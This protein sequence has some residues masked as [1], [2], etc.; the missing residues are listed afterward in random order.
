MIFSDEEIVAG[1]I[2]IIEA[3]Q[4]QNYAA[5]SAGWAIKRNGSAEFSDV[6]AR[7]SITTA[8][9]AAGNRV[10]VQESTRGG[11]SVGEVDFFT[12]VATDT[13]GSV[14][15]YGPADGTMRAL[16]LTAPA[17]AGIPVPTALSLTYDP[18]TGAT[19]AEINA[20]DTYAA[21]LHT[22]GV[23]TVKSDRVTPLG[24]FSVKDFGAAGD[25]TSDDAPEIQ[26]ALNA[27]PA[28]GVVF[29]PPGVYRTSAPVTIPPYVT[30]MGSHGGTEAESAG[31]TTPCSI[32]PLP[33][34]TGTAVVQINDQQIGGYSR[35]A[36]EIAIRNLTVDGSDIPAGTVVA[37]IQATG[38]IQGFILSDVQVRSVTGIGINTAYNLS[39]APGGPQA[40]FCLHW[41]RVSVLWAGSHGV[42][43]NNS[44]DSA[45]HDVYV[46][47]CGSFGWYISGSDNSTLTSCRAEWSGLS[48]FQLAGGQGVFRMVGCSTDRNQQN[49]ISVPSTSDTGMV[50]ISNASL[51]RDGKSNGTSGYAGLNVSGSTRKVIVDGLVVK[52]GNDTSNALVSPQFGISVTNSAYVAIGSG[53]LQ[54]VSQGWHDGSGNTSLLRGTTV[55]AT[56]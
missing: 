1:T 42:V 37:G 7:G 26:A 20:T 13:P 17:A 50:V 10:V 23:M 52:T 18:D 19:R 4:S 36:S 33:T 53:Y 38:Q 41:N 9:A 31:W 32:K 49:G 40:P 51:T 21:N 27:C 39:A 2:L 45:L 3:I 35:L 25:G 15:S 29:L 47:G 46:L 14:T 16:K 48:G 55:T 12:E 56:P 44:T 54:G 8:P 24:W 30:L 43:L 11:R 22:T 6:T 5:G 28:G 34:F